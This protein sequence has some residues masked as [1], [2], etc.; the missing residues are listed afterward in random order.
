MTI[1][2]N[3]SGVMFCRESLTGRWPDGVVS[4]DGLSGLES[5]L[6]FNFSVVFFRKRSAFRG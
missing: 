2:R 4:I 5:D 6:Q 1:V 3:G